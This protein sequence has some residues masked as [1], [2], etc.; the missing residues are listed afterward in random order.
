MSPSNRDPTASPRLSAYGRRMAS[1]VGIAAIMERVARARSRPG[2]PVIDLNA[3]NPPLFDDLVALWHDAAL[4]ALGSG[5]ARTSARYGQISGDPALI[6][7]LSAA[8]ADF[9]FAPASEHAIDEMLVTP[10]ALSFIAQ[11]AHAFVGPDSGARGRKLLLPQCPEFEGYRTLGLPPEA[12]ITV[13]PKIELVGEHEFRYIMDWQALES[14]DFT[15][16]GMV[17]LSRPCNPTGSVL[18]A[19]DLS[20]LADLAAAHGVPVVVDSVYTPPI[21]GL[22]YTDDPF[23]FIWADNIIYVF[24]LSK[25]GLPGERVGVAVGPAA[26]LRPLRMVQAHLLIMSAKLGQA[27][28][29]L[30][31]ASGEL[32]RLCRDILAPHYQSTAEHV[33][34]CLA[35][36]MRDI[37]YRTHCLD[38]GVFTWLWLPTLAGT[39]HDLLA[40][41]ERRG[42]FATPGSLFFDGLDA[43]MPGHRDRCIRISLTGD[44]DLY[45]PGIDI[46][47]ECVLLRDLHAPGELQRRPDRE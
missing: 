46:I 34:A 1:P 29:A 26:L 45:A 24:S 31:L 17:L 30:A 14:L 20:R 32:A 44:R 25:A 8:L 12:L 42:V 15:D 39:D 36:S 38:G 4:A 9:G 19:A 13:A 3:G 41:T 40:R 47:A 2:P 23:E 18:A 7:E 28:A 10:G 21:P 35:E 16:I 27:M 11:A 6:R 5:A 33:R 22:V 37:P 43:P